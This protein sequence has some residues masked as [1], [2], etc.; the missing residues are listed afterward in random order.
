[1][2]IANC[3]EQICVTLSLSALCRC[4]EPLCDDSTPLEQSDE[5]LSLPSD[6]TWPQLVHLIISFMK[7]LKHQNTLPITLVLYPVVSVDRY[8]TCEAAR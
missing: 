3:G 7:P 6:P 5:V 8:H 4:I 2:C 1:M